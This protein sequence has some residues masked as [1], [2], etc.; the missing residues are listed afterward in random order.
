MADTSTGENDVATKDHEQELCIQRVH[1]HM[2]QGGRALDETDLATLEKL[3]TE[4]SWV[5]E[6][7]TIVAMALDGTKALVVDGN[8]RARALMQ[9][10]G[11]Q[12]PQVPGG[13]TITCVADE[14]APANL[15]AILAQHGND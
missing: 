14:G 8:H 2:G 12:R 10:T 4:N 3:L 5:P 15:L 13:T 11:E 7:P 6:T 9:M 1:D